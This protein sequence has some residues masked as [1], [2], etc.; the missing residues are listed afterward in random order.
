[1]RGK[2][3]QEY[4]DE[5]NVQ[6]CCGCFIIVMAVVALVIFVLVAIHLAVTL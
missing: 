4:K 5:R 1:V 6:A 3:L 2:T